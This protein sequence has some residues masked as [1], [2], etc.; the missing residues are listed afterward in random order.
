VQNFIYLSSWLSQRL[1]RFKCAFAQKSISREKRP[2]AASVS[3]V[4]SSRPPAGALYAN[5][6]KSVSLPRLLRRFMDQNSHRKPNSGL[7][8]QRTFVICNMAA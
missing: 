8:L 1:P 7:G 4:R 2:S 5:Y 6:N 3:A